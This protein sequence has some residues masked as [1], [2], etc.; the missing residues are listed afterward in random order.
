MGPCW[1]DSQESDDDSQII[2]SPAETPSLPPKKNF[3]LVGGKA[4]KTGGVARSTVRGRHPKV[5][6][7]ELASDGVESGDED[8]D[9]A[10]EQD[11]GE[12]DDV[13]FKSMRTHAKKKEKKAKARVRGPS[14]GKGEA[15]TNGEAKAKQAKAASQAAADELCALEPVADLP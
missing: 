8:S 14:K 12:E 2:G 11:E 6:L 13:S 3:R 9:E 15:K 7:V 4:P 5:P 1:P 10:G